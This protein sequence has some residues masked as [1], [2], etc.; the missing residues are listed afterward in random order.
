MPRR[1]TFHYWC[2]HPGQVNRI[3]M[4]GVGAQN[5]TWVTGY[6]RGKQPRGGHFPVYIP[7]FE[8][9]EVRQVRGNLQ[10]STFML[11]RFKINIYIGYSNICVTLG[12]E[13]S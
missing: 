8:L 6:K 1:D 5:I 10:Y 9:P 4:R 2:S 11:M 7:E 12:N 3:P 13:L